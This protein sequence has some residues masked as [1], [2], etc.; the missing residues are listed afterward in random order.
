VHL[1]KVQ[2]EILDINKERVLLSILSGVDKKEWSLS[3][4]ETPY[5][6]SVDST[7]YRDMVR[8]W[9]HANILIWIDPQKQ[10]FVQKPN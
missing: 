6:S 7:S 5:V 1:K 3:L 2:F 10:I 8:R 9:V 4:S